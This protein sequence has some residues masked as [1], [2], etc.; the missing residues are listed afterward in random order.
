MTIKPDDPARLSTRFA[1]ARSGP[2][3]LARWLVIH[4]RWLFWIVAGLCVVGLFVS[5]VFD[6]LVE[7]LDWRDFWPH[8]A[9]LREWAAAPDLWSAGNPHYASDAPSREYTPWFLVLVLAMRWFGLSQFGAQ[10][11]AACLGTLLLYGGLYAFLRVFLRSRVA[12]VL[13]LVAAFFLWADVWEFVGFI[14]YRSQ[15]YNNYYPSVGALGVVLFVWAL[16]VAELRHPSRWRPAALATLFALL[17]INHQLSAGYALGGAALFIV[18][19]PGTSLRRRVLVAAALVIGGALSA[20]WPIYNPWSVVIQGGDSDPEWA[21]PSQFDRLGAV[22]CFMAPQFLGLVGLLHPRLRRGMLPI[23]LGFAGCFAAFLYGNLTGNSLAHRLIPFAAL[24]LSI[25]V[26]GFWLLLWPSAAPGVV[27]VREPWRRRAIIASIALAALGIGAQVG[28]V[29]RD[30][31]RSWLFDRDPVMTMFERVSAEIPP[32]AVSL[33]TP[34]VALSLTSFGRKVVS[35]PRGLFL[36]P[37]EAERHADSRLFFAARTGDEARRVIIAR[38]GV[39][40]IV[41]RTGRF[42]GPW[43]H[44]ELPDTTIAAL[45]RLGP[46]RDLPFRFVIVEVGRPG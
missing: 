32:D 30:Y 29:A 27:P 28:D 14:N 7:Y 24:F 26:A 21:P 1:E 8:A 42:V 25:G 33:A 13:G 15:L 23:T 22:L 46:S 16:I 3:P 37:D 19:E 5:F 9:V 36:V 12:P 17:M 43:W 44:D 4:E 39:S 34:G 10:Q 35:I 11:L 31:L 40:R 6:P 45:R 38:W 18:L 2:L 41:V 20:L